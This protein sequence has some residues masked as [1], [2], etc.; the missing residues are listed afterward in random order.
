MHVARQSKYCV[1][2]ERGGPD[3]SIGSAMKIVK[4]WGGE[5]E[6]PGHFRAKCYSSGEGMPNDVLSQ[7]SEDIV[8]VKE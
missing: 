3:G 4:N 1:C 2:Q 6:F 8:S 7:G 5:R